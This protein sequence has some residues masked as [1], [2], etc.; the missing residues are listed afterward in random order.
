[1]T[2]QWLSYSGSVMAHGM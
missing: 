2:L 1:M